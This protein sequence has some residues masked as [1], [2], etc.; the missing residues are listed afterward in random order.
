[1]ARGITIGGTSQAVPIPGNGDY[2]RTFGRPG[3]VV[4]GT[5]RGAVEI[6]VPMGSSAPGGSGYLLP[7]AVEDSIPG[8]KLSARLTRVF[9]QATGRESSHCQAQQ[10]IMSH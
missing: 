9:P 7:L 10:S 5:Q 6:R 1:V 2:A 3:P 8:A 4:Q